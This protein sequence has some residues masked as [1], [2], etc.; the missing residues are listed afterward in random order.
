M[1]IELKAGMRLQ[2]PPY[3]DKSWITL[4]KLVG[5]R[6][7][8]QELRYNWL[9]TEDRC[10]A[11]DYLQYHGR[12]A[13]GESVT[14]SPEALTNERKSTHGDWNLQAEMANRLK[15]QLRRSP[16]WESMVPMQKEALDMIATKMSRIVC[17]NSQHDDHWDDIQGY[18]HLGKGGHT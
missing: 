9:D 2:M 5:F 17:G 1:P 13:Y 7:C 14:N 15:E 11:E 10:W 18:A 6:D 4:N 3:D 12:I 8:S 16:G